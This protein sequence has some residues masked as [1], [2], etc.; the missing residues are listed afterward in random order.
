MV[1]QDVRAAGLVTWRTRRPR[2]GQPVRQLCVHDRRRGRAK[3]RGRRL[4]IRRAPAVRVRVP[5]R[6]GGRRGR[7]DGQRAERQRQRG[8]RV[9]RRVTG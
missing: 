9:R 6:T 5:G 1:R 7:V 3:R 8:G 4:R 2:D